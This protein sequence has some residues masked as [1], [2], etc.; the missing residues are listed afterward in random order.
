MTSNQ[1]LVLQWLQ[2]NCTE[3]GFIKCSNSKIADEFGWS[4]PYALKMLRKLVDLGYLEELQKGIGHR[5]TKYRVSFSHNQNGSSHNR[6]EEP[7]HVR[8][9]P[10]K[11]FAP[12]R[13]NNVLPI[14]STKDNAQT[15][16]HVQNIFDNVAIRVRKPARAGSSPFKRFRKRCDTVEKWNSTDF[17]CY[18]SFVYKVRF[19]EMPK[20]EWSKECGAAR[21]LLRRI[22]D[23]V[24]FKAFIQIAFAICKRPPNGL[25]TFSFGNFYEDVI[26][27]EL[28]D[29]ILDE[30]DDEYVYPWLKIEL[31]RRSTDAAVEYQRHLNRVYLGL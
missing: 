15:K 18:F 13:L 23:P 12:F 16:A 14:G 30:Y 21:T 2:D 6:R 3:S 10:Q 19:G 1:R 11:R 27:R 17:V 29:N 9:E 26:S 8:K 22:K 31:Q 5:P 4:Q 20:L 25:Y 24:A 7:N 28:D